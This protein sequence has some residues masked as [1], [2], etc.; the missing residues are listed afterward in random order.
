M[1]IYQIKEKTLETNPYFFNT[2]TLKFFGQTLKSFNVHK[3]SETK[4]LIN[5]PIRNNGK[6][7]GITEKIF[8]TENNELETSKQESINL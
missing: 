4:Y 1:T 8:N 2:K 5:A 3:I 7:I 6:K